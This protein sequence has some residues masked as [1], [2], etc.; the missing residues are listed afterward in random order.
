MDSKKIVAV[1]AVLII[2]AAGVTAYLMVQD[3]PSSTKKSTEI[4]TVAVYG[5]V[6]ND[7]Y[8]DDEDLSALKEIINDG[9]W[10]SDKNP[11]ADVNYDSKVDEDDVTHLE[12]LLGKEKTKM[13]YVGSFGDVVYFNYPVADRKIAASSDY[14]LMLAQVLGIYDRIVAGSD[15]VLSYSESRY[16]GCK[17]LASLGSYTSSDYPT[18]VENFLDSGCTV[19]L[20]QV[21]QKVYD[22]L[23]DTNQE[24]DLILLSASAEVQS[25]GMDVVSSILTA[26]ILLDCGDQARTYAEYFDKITNYLDTETSGVVPEDYLLIYNPSN[27]TTCTIH[28]SGGGGWKGD[29]WNLQYLPLYTDFEWN[30]TAANGKSNNVEVETVLDMDPEIIILSIWNK[31]DDDTDPEEVQKTVDEMAKYFSHTTAYKTG[32]I[33]AV[34]YEMYGAYLGVGGLY[35]LASYIWPDQFDEEQGWKL[36][37]EAVDDFTMIDADVH[38]LG[39]MIPYKVNTTV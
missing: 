33:Y 2:V 9:N 6:N 32:N 30:G 23:R 17:S 28:T 31:A 16:P 21:T 25:N 5:N 20:G 24:V 35:L 38:D 29:A 7:N 37:Q 34:N 18:F 14:G 15:K 12:K 26:G 4:G 22:M 3:T 11:F 19:L 10:D 1:V 13:Y 36:L 27:P 39:G 8:L